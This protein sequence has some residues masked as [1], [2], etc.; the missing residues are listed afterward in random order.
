[1]NKLIEQ[2]ETLPAFN[3]LKA[4]LKEKLTGEN[5]YVQEFMQE[6]GDSFEYRSDEDDV[7]ATSLSYSD[8]E[9]EGVSELINDQTGHFDEFV[10]EE[11]GEEVVEFIR[12][13]IKEVA[14]KTDNGYRM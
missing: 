4:A 2:L 7:I 13:L 3:K 12:A 11:I 9:D 14:I 6:P 1:M 8:A 5:I 10:S